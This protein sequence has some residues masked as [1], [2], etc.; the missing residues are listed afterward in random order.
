M[1]KTIKATEAARRFSEVL[2]RVK[3]RG[4]HYIIV[5]GG[6]PVAS[7]GPVEILQKEHTLGELKGL[8]EKIPGLGDEAVV[9]EADMREVIKYQ[10]TLPREMEW[11]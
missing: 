1:E 7:I 2:N 10:P 5:R 9:Y 4:N 6:K 3:F 11:E 8:L